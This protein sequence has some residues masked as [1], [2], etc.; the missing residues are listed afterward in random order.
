MSTGYLGIDIGTASSK[1]VLV[2]SAG[3]LIR[4][5]VRSHD[6]SWPRPGWAE[7]DAT[8][9]WD[10]FVAITREL[11]DGFD[12]AIA[13]VGVSGMGPCVLVT[14]GSGQLLRPAILYGIDTRATPQIAA[15][16]A[17][18]G[19]GAI[20]DRCGS[21]LSTQAVGPKLRWLAEE[22]A[23]VA[24]AA[25]RLFMPNSWLVW[26]LT[27]AYLLDHHSASQCTPLYD[28]S[29]NEW[30]LPWTST[31]APLLDLPELRWPGELA[32]LVTAGASAVTGLPAGT[33]V[34][35]GTIDAWAEAV[36]VG[37]TDPGDLMVMYGTTM[38]LIATQ[39]TPIRSKAL[40]TTTGAF[41]GTNSLAGGMATSGA[42]TSWLRA[43][44][45]TPPFGTLL[46]EA[47]Q[48]GAGA[49]GLLML[50]YFAGERTPIADPQA[51]GTVLGLT[52][53]H[54]RGDLYR[55]A[56]EGT[57]FGVRD[58]I[59][60]MRNAGADIRRV[61]AVGGGTT[62][63]LWTQI[64]SDVTGYA[65]HV[66]AHTIGASLGGAFLAARLFDDVN[67]HDWNPIASTTSPE[68][69]TVDLYNQRYEL[70]RETYRATKTISHALARAQETAIHRRNHP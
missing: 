70:Y 18:L 9:W 54:T 29:T 34:I 13:A 57:A 62:G 25:R 23:H 61:V 33:P 41:P 63:G 1:G 37:A 12:G 50:P 68:P 42:I 64:V 60:A 20:A 11:L 48:S 30:Y 2:G 66:P 28:E 40:W 36:S 69:E 7:M 32:G 3:E 14:D 10:E 49:N 39:D 45:G 35:I 31:I 47:H 21:R 24:A 58:N 8:I 43:L 19:D 26:Q 16:T 67:I 52:T 38:F 15:M 53:S 27:G 59:E 55:A 22:E 5:A 46:D 17:E 56:L 65:Q 4:T 51:R 6:I 44:Y